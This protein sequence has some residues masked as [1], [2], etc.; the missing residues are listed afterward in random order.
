MTQ[1]TSGTGRGGKNFQDRKLAADVR[2]LALNQVMEVLSGKRYKN[3]KAYHK[4]LLLK[5]AGTVLPRLN[6]VTGEDGGPIEISDLSNLSDA[7]LTKLTT[8]S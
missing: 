5:L 2:T 1:Y 6:E 8:R 3:D 7:E 4:A